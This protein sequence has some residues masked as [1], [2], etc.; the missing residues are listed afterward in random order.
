MIQRVICSEHTVVIELVKR[1]NTWMTLKG[2]S[3]KTVI[4]SL[5]PRLR[6][7]TIAPK[8]TCAFFAN[9][10]ALAKS[11]SLSCDYQLV[12]KNPFNFNVLSFNLE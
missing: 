8:V 2:S 11:A 12:K 10:S 1:Q 7:V 6:I 3:K 4:V 5:H 9:T